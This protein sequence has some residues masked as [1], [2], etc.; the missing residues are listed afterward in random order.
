VRSLRF[1][2]I[3]R[4]SLGPLPPSSSSGTLLCPLLLCSTAAHRSRPSLATSCC[5]HLHASLP[6]P[7]AALASPLLASRRLPRPSL[8]LPELPPSDSSSPP[9]RMLVPPLFPRPALVIVSSFGS[10]PS[11]SSRFPLPRTHQALNATAA[12]S[13]NSSAILFAVG[14]PPQSSPHHHNPL[15]SFPS[16]H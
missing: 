11:H 9:W 12:P 13:L 3:S 2:Q 7:S 5:L 16:P 15:G 6:S 4:K 8:F 1:L 10:S 14:S